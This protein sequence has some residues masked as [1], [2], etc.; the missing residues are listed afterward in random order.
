MNDAE[1]EVYGELT[2]VLMVLSEANAGDYGVRVHTDHPADHPLGALAAGVNS[3]LA[4]LETTPREA[5]ASAAVA[6]LPAWPVLRIAD[7]A[8]LVVL[9]GALDAVQADRTVGRVVDAVAAESAR[10]AVL[11]LTAVVSLDPAAAERIGRAA[12][13]L[14][15]LG[16]EMLLTGVSREVAEVVCD[17]DVPLVDV[18][19]LPTLADAIARCAAPG[20]AST[21]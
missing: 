3:L 19:V 15:M 21:T 18:T 20:A 1:L 6:P 9:A 17:L 2:E 16:A 11:D 10:T 14:R 12:R 13:T 5:T 7:R 4:A 8:L